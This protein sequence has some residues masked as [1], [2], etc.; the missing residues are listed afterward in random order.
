MLGL[1]HFSDYLK[2]NEGLTAKVLSQR[3]K[4]MEEEGIINKSIVN[5]NPVEIE[6]SLT[7][8]GWDLK[9]VLFE[10]SMYG[11][12]YY[13]KQVFGDNELNLDKALDL[14]GGGFMID[15]ED[16]DRLRKPTVTFNQ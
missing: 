15:K 7:E 4:D 11:A 2:T 8:Q 16:I 3:L 10:L 14:F 9:K 12:K 1:K 13:P 6:Y 5:T